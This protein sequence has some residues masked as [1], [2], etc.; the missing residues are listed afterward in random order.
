MIKKYTSLFFLTLTLLLAFGGGSVY[1]MSDMDYN[2]IDVAGQ[3]MDFTFQQD[4]P[5]SEDYTVWA[6]DGSIYIKTNKAVEVNIYT[7]TGQ[8]SKR[9]KVTV[10]E[11]SVP[12][13][14]GLY[15]VRIDNI[16]RKVI[17]K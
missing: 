16:T 13:T 5:L 4:D 12:M 7:I 1:A 2:S 15:I 10:G 6:A 14:R 9:M 11:T 17:V 8:L 3:Y